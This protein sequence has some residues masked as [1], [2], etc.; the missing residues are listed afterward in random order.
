MAYGNGMFVAA[1]FPTTATAYST[2]GI[3]WSGGNATPSG[4]IY[5]GLAAVH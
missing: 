1:A 2:D 3:H 4:V 5:H